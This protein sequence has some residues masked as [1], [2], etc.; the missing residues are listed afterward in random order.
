MTGSG[1]T[2]I[3]GVAARRIVR[4]TASAAAAVAILSCSWACGGG[5]RVPG[6]GDGSMGARELSG[7]TSRRF[8]RSEI[9]ELAD[10][11]NERLAP[12]R[13]FSVEERSPGTTEKHPPMNVL[14][15]VAAP[16]RRGDGTADAYET[17]PEF[18]CMAD[19]LN[20]PAATRGE[21]ADSMRRQDTDA[22]EPLSWNDLGFRGWHDA[23]G[24]A[25]LVLTWYDPAA[26][27][28]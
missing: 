23:G 13:P 12:E 2:H 9:V 28:R 6:A 19:A 15:A 24:D 7:R 3:G 8:T 1:N 25:H 14:I 18:V 11:C 4:A 16:R 21:L 20:M 5:G 26:A 27:E 10:S 17:T 22:A